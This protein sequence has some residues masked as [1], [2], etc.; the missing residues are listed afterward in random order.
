MLGSQPMLGCKYVPTHITPGGLTEVRIDMSDYAAHA[1]E[2]FWKRATGLV[3]QSGKEALTPADESVPAGV[4][5]PSPGR[6]AS[7]GPSFNGALM[8]LTRCAVF[9]CSV[10]VQLLSRC[11]HAWSTATDAAC[12]RIYQWVA[13]YATTGTLLLQVDPRDLVNG[14]L[15]LLAFTD[16]DHAGDQS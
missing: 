13:K 15:Q 8:W 14:S 2:E 10:A 1:A 4:V 12:T 9:Q 11:L 5:D 7:H 3:G 16:A 6:L